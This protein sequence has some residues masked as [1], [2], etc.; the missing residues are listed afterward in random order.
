[1]MWVYVQ[2]EMVLSEEFGLAVFEGVIYEFNS[3]VEVTVAPYGCEGTR[4]IGEVVP[5][6]SGYQVAFEFCWD[7]LFPDRVVE[8]AV[9]DRCDGSEFGVVLKILKVS[10]CDMPKCIGYGKQEEGYCCEEL[11]VIVKVHK[12]VLSEDCLEDQILCFI[13]GPCYTLKL[14]IGLGYDVMYVG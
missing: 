2:D 9:H 5:C 7:C 8:V 6:F 1:M 3:D 12:F 13:A 4:K 11:F 10:A 14:P